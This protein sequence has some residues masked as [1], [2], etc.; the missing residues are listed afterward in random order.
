MKRT[1]FSR[2]L[3]SRPL[4]SAAPSVL[5][6][7]RSEVARAHA[8]DPSVL[9]RDGPLLD[10]RRRA[11]HE[12]GDC[13]PGARHPPVA[14][15]AGY[16][17]HTDVISHQKFPGGGAVVGIGPMQIALVVPVRRL[18][19]GVHH[20]PVGVI[21]EQEVRILGQ[22]LHGVLSRS[23]DES[24]AVALAGDVSQLKRIPAAQRNLSAAVQHLAAQVEVLIDDD[25]GRPEIARANG[26][27]QPGAPAADDHHV[28]LVVPLNGFDRGDLR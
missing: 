20:R 15:R 11:F 28:G 13:A 9:L 22:L 23:S 12:E 18:G 2:A 8:S 24:F 27:R 17:T 16:P 21:P 5:H 14:V 25:D 26:G 1:P 19:R 6:E 10:V 4:E 3:N 7:A